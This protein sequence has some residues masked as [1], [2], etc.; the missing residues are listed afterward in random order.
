MAISEI[1]YRLFRA[2]REKDVIPLGGKVLQIGANA[3][4]G[5]VAIRNLADDIYRFGPVATRRELFVEL[6]RAWQA[7]GP[8]FAVQAASIYWRTFFQ[9]VTLTTLA[10]ARD[11]EPGPQFDVVLNLRA[12]Q[13]HDVQGYMDI[14]QRT[15]PGGLMIHAAPFAGPDAPPPAFFWD[16]AAANDYE[17]MTMICASLGPFGM[18]RFQAP[19]EELA[20]RQDGAM[21]PTSQLHV[22]L[23]RPQ[24]DRPYRAPDPACAVAGA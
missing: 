8:D 9:P 24:A 23:R 21:K 18:A 5:D 12:P 13:G 22:V 6:D 14:H 1:E 3:W 20:A 7:Q 16:L 17:V 15:R 10:A 11:A 2:L 19:A 4:Q